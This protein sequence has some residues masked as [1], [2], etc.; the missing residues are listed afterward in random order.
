MPSWVDSRY[1]IGVT[2][3]ASLWSKPISDKFGGTM[4]REASW[5]LMHIVPLR[6]IF[7]SSFRKEITNNMISSASVDGNF[8]L[9]LTSLWGY[10]QLLNTVLLAL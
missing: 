2:L 3:P 8:T 1:I 5:S 4:L 10:C 6:K 7:K 9:A